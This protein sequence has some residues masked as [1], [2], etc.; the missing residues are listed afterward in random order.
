MR[1]V[2]KNVPWRPTGLF[3]RFSLEWL[4]LHFFTSYHYLIVFSEFIFLHSL[5]LSWNSFYQWRPMQF[6]AQQIPAN[7]HRRVLQLGQYFSKYWSW[8]STNN[9]CES[10]ESSSTLSTN[11]S[12]EWIL[13]LSWSNHLV[14][15]LGYKRMLKAFLNINAWRVIPTDTKTISPLLVSHKSMWILWQELLKN[16]LSCSSLKIWYFKYCPVI[17]MSAALSLEIKRKLR[18]NGAL[19]SP[20]IL[21][22]IS[23][24]YIIR[25]CMRTMS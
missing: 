14:T 9:L 19:V 12:I 10:A 4:C 7:Q 24:V 25:E 17:L 20:T 2:C 16:G 21:R 22:S 5:Q 8:S 3:C 23:S 11:T 13:Y 6:L 15:S 18:S 1:N